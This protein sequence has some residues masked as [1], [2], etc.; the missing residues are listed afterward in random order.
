V[1]STFEQELKRWRGVGSVGFGAFM[2]MK[3]MFSFTPEAKFGEVTRVFF[4]RTLNKGVSMLGQRPTH[5]GSSARFS[6]GHQCVQRCG[7]GRGW[8]TVERPK[9]SDISRVHQ[10]LVASD[11]YP[12]NASNASL[13]VSGTL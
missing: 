2:E 8:N 9:S 7:T 4:H 12:L 13:S 10:T 11:D 5:V 3:C 6:A 1:V